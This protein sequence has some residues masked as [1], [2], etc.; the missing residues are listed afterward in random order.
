MS[1]PNSRDLRISF[2]HLAIFQRAQFPIAPFRNR[3]HP[4]QQTAKSETECVRR[5]MEF[6][7][8]RKVHERLQGKFTDSPNGRE[9]HGE[10]NRGSRKD[11]E[12]LRYT[13]A[14]GTHYRQEEKRESNFTG[15]EE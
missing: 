10:Y 15:R 8:L 14:H 6:R 9:N 4:P 5:A 11:D 7:H 3:K 13:R 1:L 2:R 12:N